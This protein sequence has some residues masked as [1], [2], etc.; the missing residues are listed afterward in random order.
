MRLL[1]S[2]DYRL[3]QI[4][5]TEEVERIIEEARAECRILRTGRLAGALARC[6]PNS[7]LTL[8]ELVDQIAAAGASAGIPVEFDGSERLQARRAPLEKASQQR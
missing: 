1:R 4:L 3:V 8:R 7:G 5:I 6:F 2:P